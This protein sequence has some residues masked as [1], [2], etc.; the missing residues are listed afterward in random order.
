MNTHAHTHTH[1]TTPRTRTHTHTHTHTQ[2]PHRVNTHTHTHTHTPRDASPVNP[3]SLHPTHTTISS[4]RN[5]ILI[6]M[7]FPYANPNNRFSF[8]A[9]NSPITAHVPLRQL[10]GE[11]SL[12]PVQYNTSCR[13]RADSQHG[14]ETFILYYTRASVSTHDG[15]STTWRG[16]WVW[17]LGTTVTPLRKNI[18]KTSF[19]F[20]PSLLVLC[21]LSSHSPLSLTHT[22]THTHTDP[23]TRTH[24]THTHAHTLTHIHTP[25]HTHTYART[26][27]HTH[28][29]TRTQLPPDRSGS[30]SCT[31]TCTHTRTH[32]HAHTRTHTHTHTHTHT[33]LRPS[34]VGVARTHS[35]E[36]DLDA[37]SRI[38][39]STTCVGAT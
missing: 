18:F 6:Q 39:S 38:I 29:N 34:Q 9:I 4:R 35:C 10:K 17:G 8:S 21:Q 5:S 27:T 30:H 36:I 13:R 37:T 33:R 7:E 1:R 12:D 26:H 15:G 20:S 14:T 22:H 24:D 19:L 16:V 23:R 11:K 2:T 32:T 28:M 25:T 3:T 31:H